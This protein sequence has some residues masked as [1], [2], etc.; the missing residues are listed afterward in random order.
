MTDARLSFTSEVTDIR[1]ESR[2]GSI[3]RWQIALEHTLFS[4]SAPTGVLVAVAPSGARLEVPV[5]AVFE[6]DGTTWHVVDKPLTAGTEVTG[7]LA[8]HLC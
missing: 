1:L 7:T 6:Q 3:A 8:E 5:L 4:E 2:A